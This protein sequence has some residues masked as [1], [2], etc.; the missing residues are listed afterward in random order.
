MG[1]LRVK[2]IEIRISVDFDF[3][4][5]IHIRNR[6]GTGSSALNWR[7]NQFQIFLSPGLA[8]GDPVT[9]VYIDHPPPS[10]TYN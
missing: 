6:Y 1:R 5:C 9:I 10:V 2:F 3:F 8:V 4:E 7:E